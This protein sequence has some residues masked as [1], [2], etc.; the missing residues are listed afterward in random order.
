L[1]SFVRIV[2]EIIPRSMFEVL[3]QIIKL[4]TVDLKELPTKIEKDKMLE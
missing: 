4:Q 1:V 3:G 2:L